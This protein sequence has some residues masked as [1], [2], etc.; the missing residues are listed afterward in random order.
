VTFHTSGASAKHI[1]TKEKPRSLRFTSPV[2]Q[3]VRQAELPVELPIKAAGGRGVLVVKRFAATGF[4]IDE[5]GAPV[6]IR[7]DAEVY[8]AEAS[9]ARTRRDEA[10]ELFGRAYRTGQDFRD[11]TFV[12]DGSVI[13]WHR[14][15][16]EV[17]RK[18]YGEAEAALFQNRLPPE[19]AFDPATRMEWID[20][21]MVP[22]AS[23]IERAESLEPLEDFTAEDWYGLFP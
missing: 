10:K 7:I 17:A 6:G 8:F 12:D 21:H 14:D 3:I 19:S 20:K 5:A 9:P 16:I 23:L 22:L 2:Q 15:L 1:N 13:L 4:D 11:N 18:A